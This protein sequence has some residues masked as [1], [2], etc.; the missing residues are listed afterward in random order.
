[1]RPLKYYVATTLDGFIAHP[2]GSFDGFPFDQ[3]VVADFF[4]AFEGFDA[5]LMGRKTYEVGL[6]EGKTDPYPMMKGY[7][8]SRTMEASPDDNV[9]LISQDAASRV[10][11]LKEEP[12]KAIWLCGGA[13]LASTLFAADLIDEL[14][15][16]LNPVVFGAGISLL[17]GA[18][19][20]TRFEL[21]EHKAY[22]GGTV[23][24]H[25]RLI[26]SPTIHSS[27]TATTT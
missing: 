25:Y 13:E 10:Q 26:S 20:P 23:L 21:T 15:L 8:F 7:L 6:R 4:A 16:K 18:V 2:D 14:I 24:L 22:D 27:P 11:A 17:S 12:G 5:V 1:M 9:E 19:E 3:E